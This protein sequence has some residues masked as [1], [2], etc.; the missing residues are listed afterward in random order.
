MTTTTRDLNAIMITYPNFSPRKKVDPPG[1]TRARRTRLND[2]I[3]A[4]SYILHDYS[5]FND[6]NLLTFS[7]NFVGR[8]TEFGTRPYFSICSATYEYKNTSLQATVY[9][10]KPCGA[11]NMAYT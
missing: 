11:Y 4:D 2:I 7:N 3:P 1:K 8:H 9:D 6:Y 5:S 10:T